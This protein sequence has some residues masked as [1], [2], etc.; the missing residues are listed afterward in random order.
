MKRALVLIPLFLIAGP[1]VAQQDVVFKAMRDELSRSMKKL[2]LEHLEK[3]YFVAYKVVESDS[4]NAAASFGSLMAS[5]QNRS[6]M[7]G[8][9]V[10]VGDYA[11]D[12]ANFFS[13]GFGGTGV[14]RMFGGNLSLPLDDNYDEIRRQIWLATDG[15]YKKALEDLAKKRAALQNKNRTDLVPDFSSEKPTETTDVAPLVNIE[16]VDAEGR[17]KQLSAIFRAISGVFTSQVRLEVSNVFTRY[18]NSDGTSFTRKAP[19]IAL[20][21]TAATQATDGMPLADFVVAYGRAA[22][23]LPSLDQLTALVR[24]MGIRLAMLREAPVADRY[25]GPVLFENQAA[26]ELFSQVF[27]PQILGTPRMITDNPQFER[28]FGSDEDNLLDKIGARVMPDFLKL[29]DSPIA[30]SFQQIPLLG[31]Y[32]MDEDGV[33]ARETVVVENGI[34]KTLLTGRGPMRGILQSSG[35][36]RGTGV[37]P[38]N[39]LLISQKAMSTDALRAEFLRLVKQRGKEY[40]IVV[41]RIGNPGVRGGGQGMSFSFSSAGPSRQGSRVEPAIAAYQV[42]LDGREQLIRNAT[43][44][45]L[46]VATFKEIVAVCDKP[47]VYTAP[48]SVRSANPFTFN[49][50]GTTP[51]VSFVVPSLLFD[52]VT[53]QKPS[54]EIPKPP[55]SKHPSFEK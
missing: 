34:L 32:K 50:G 19:W 43:I 17:V 35:N 46:T 41:R 47:V 40:G 10:R 33:R 28:A 8:V 52:D 24:A 39:L 4:K 29:V 22:A 15:A 16:L 44:A 25:N 36:R 1:L 14:V 30:A 6:R 11:L 12:N 7:L 9:E 5:G 48:F 54:G 27:A 20:T 2:Q 13:I 51:V 42:F 23:D 49:P 26:A 53:V 18:V 21:A 37:M 45:G 3:P 55:F 31:G 38:S